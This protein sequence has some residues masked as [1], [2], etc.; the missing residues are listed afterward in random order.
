MR[1]GQVRPVICQDEML[2]SQEQ[3]KNDIGAIMAGQRKTVMLDKELKGIIAV[4]KQQ[5]QI[6]IRSSIVSC[7]RHSKM[8]TQPDP[9]WKPHIRSSRCSRQWQ[10]PK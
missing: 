8:R 7:W 4:V 3:L 6:Y 5:I 9:T 2:P 10:K 1:C